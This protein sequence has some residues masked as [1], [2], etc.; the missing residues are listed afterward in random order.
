MKMKLLLISVLMAV[1]TGSTAGSIDDS[2]LGLSKTS[3]FDTP[4]PSAFEYPDIKAGKSD[5]LPRAYSGYEGAPPQVSHTFDKYLPITAED[6][7]CMDCH[8]KPDKIGK[9]YVK[10]K[11][12]PMPRSHYGGFAGKGD[13]ETVSGAR[14]VCT[15]CHVPQSDAQPLVENTLR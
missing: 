5:R 3:V 1:A 8:D 10:G 12:L 15:Q 4:T 11:K 13:M 6:N 9:E 2:A 7:Q 14:Y